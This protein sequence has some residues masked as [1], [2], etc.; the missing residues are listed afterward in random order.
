M[1]LLGG[2][3]KAQE[4]SGRCEDSEM[5]VPVHVQV[6]DSKLDPA[7]P[8]LLELGAVRDLRRI[9][10]SANIR[11]RTSCS[12]EA[13]ISKSGSENGDLHVYDTATGEEI[14]DY[15]R[16]RCSSRTAAAASVSRLHRIR[17][18]FHPPG[19]NPS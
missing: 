9:F 5:H 13:S 18:W 15:P 10:E 17:C 6:I 3:R 4:N 7:V 1:M 2:R 19:T 12:W 8:S 14:G 11:R 16:A